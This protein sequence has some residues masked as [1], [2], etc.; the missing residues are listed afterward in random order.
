MSHVSTCKLFV[1][2]W[3]FRSSHI[4]DLQNRIVEADQ[5][6]AGDKSKRPFYDDLR[7]MAE[8]RIG[9]NHLISKVRAC[10][11]II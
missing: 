10:V 2:L 9:M 11:V 1:T 6:A 3:C 7:S 8:Y 4:L 5:G